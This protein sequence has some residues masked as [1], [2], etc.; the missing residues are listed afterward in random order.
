MT[1]KNV[2]PTFDDFV[3]VSRKQVELAILVRQFRR[4][5][6]LSQK[7]M[8]NICSLYGKP[9]NVIF[10]QT[11]ICKYENYKTIPTPPKFTT[12]MNAMDTSL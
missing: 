2:N 8:A 3:V 11:D 7:E 9:R 12:L 4:I 1:K 10:S 5:H 6:N